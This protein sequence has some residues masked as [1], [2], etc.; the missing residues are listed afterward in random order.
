[1][2]QTIVRWEM[3]GFLAAAAGIAAFQILT[4]RINTKGLFRTGPNG[5]LS[6]TRVQMMFTVAGFALWY[7]EQVHRSTDYRLPDIPD[8]VLLGIAGSQ[9]AYL[10]GKGFT[11][12]NW[13]QYLKKND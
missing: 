1:M 11:S 3:I 6:P 12:L 13:Q 8:S 9:S 5:S 10:L 7:L 2:F 4:G